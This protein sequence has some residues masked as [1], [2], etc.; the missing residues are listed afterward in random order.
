MRA[1]LT[2]MR[3]AALSRL[4]RAITTTLMI[5]L[6][7]MIVWDIFVRRWGSAAPPASDVTQR[8]P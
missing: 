2:T 6:A 7:A 1:D 4:R 5:V 8:S 3:E